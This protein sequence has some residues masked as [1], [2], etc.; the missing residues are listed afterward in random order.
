MAVTPFIVAIGRY[1]RHITPKKVNT[2]VCFA[3][4]SRLA[5]ASYSLLSL[6]LLLIIVIATPLATV[7]LDA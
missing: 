3:T 4:T 6:P 5:A 7:T 2:S 1:H